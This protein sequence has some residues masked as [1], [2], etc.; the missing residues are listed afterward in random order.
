VTL[1]AEHQAKSQLWEKERMN[2]KEPWS[3]PTMNAHAGGKKYSI[4]P[5]C[6]C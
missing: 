5:Q 1:P 4:F 2:R 6:Y 3:F